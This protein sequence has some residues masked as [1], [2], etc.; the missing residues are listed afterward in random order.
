MPSIHV[1]FLCLQVLSFLHDFLAM[2]S[3]GR[4]SGGKKRSVCQAPGSSSAPAERK[5]LL[6]AHHRT[7]MNQLE[8]FLNGKSA[9]QPAA[10]VPYVRL[11]GDTVLDERQSLTHRFRDDASIQVWSWKFRR[12]SGSHNRILFQYYVKRAPGWRHGSG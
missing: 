7:V 1:F 6:F 4:G 5:V 8:M 11:D 2:S 10:P 3:T 9:I 12:F